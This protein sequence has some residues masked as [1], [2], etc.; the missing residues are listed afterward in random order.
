MDL[1]VVNYPVVKD[2][3]LVS[4]LCCL[5]ANVLEVL[6][7]KIVNQGDVSLRDR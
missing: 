3:N 5:L 1:W 2:R 6:D 4:P 7:L